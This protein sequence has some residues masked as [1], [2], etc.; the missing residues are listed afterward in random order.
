MSHTLALSDT[1]DVTAAAPLAQELVGLRGQPV[2]LDASAVRRLGG[3][4]LQV[5]LSA[6]AAWS[7]DGQAFEIVNASPEFTDGLA[8]MGAPDLANSEWAD[9]GLAASSLA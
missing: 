6:R 1:L 8:L 4:C 7:T 2:S 3:L 5:L 9:L